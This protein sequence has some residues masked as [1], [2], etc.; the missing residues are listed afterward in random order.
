V[1]E[2]ARQD[3]HAEGELDETPGSKIKPVQLGRQIPKDDTRF[4][5][6]EW[7]DRS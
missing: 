2:R 5:L 3:R 4:I 7:R 1:A 6:P